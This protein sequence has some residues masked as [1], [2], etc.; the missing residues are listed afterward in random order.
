MIGARNSTRNFLL[1]TSF[2]CH[3]VVVIS[4]F[5]YVSIY[6]P[7]TISLLPSFTHRHTQD[8]KF[9]IEARD[10]GTKEVLVIDRL[11]QEIILE[12]NSTPLLW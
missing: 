10:P 6:S 5:F 4:L 9:Y 2:P 7:F 11:S 8:D 1:D 12:G 3:L